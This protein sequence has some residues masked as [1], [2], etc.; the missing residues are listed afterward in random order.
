MFRT[1]VGKLHRVV[2][3]VFGLGLVAVVT[4]VA[5][6]ERIRVT[7][8]DMNM[9]LEAEIDLFSGRPNPRWQMGATESAH[10]VSLLSQLP[11]VAD[12]HLPAALGYRGIIVSS[13]SGT[14]AGY[15]RVVCYRGMVFGQRGEAVE[16]FADRDRALER[17]LAERASPHLD[18]DLQAV[19]REEG[20]R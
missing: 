6:E 8:E 7:R 13:A 1:G 5:A 9:N 3:V 17:W 15:D 18:P 4:A 19:F 11:A 16:V 2:C 20:L 10:F 14:V 12:G